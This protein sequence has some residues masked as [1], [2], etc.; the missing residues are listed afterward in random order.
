MN[1][2]QA[3]VIYACTATPVSAPPEQSDAPKGHQNLALNLDDCKMEIVQIVNKD[4]PSA[5]VDFTKPEEWFRVGAT[6]GM[7]W[8]HKHPGWYIY[9][10]K[11]P[12]PNTGELP[13]GC[14][15]TIKCPHNEH[16]I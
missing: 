2:V 3:L 7:E 11:G 8:E 1:F 13:K 14:P 5:E 12:N 6:I 9:R 10:I 16:S 15:I 4:D